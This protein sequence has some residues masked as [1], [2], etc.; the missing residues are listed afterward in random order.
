MV[1]KWSLNYL[2][3]IYKN[4]NYSS[5]YQKIFIHRDQLK[6]IDKKNLN[7]FSGYRVLLNE[8]EIKNYLSTIDFAIIKQENYY[9]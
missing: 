5:N 9:F 8:N 3:K 6:L 7:K 4:K 2:N 1:K